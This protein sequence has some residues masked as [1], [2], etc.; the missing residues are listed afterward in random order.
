M[1]RQI[2][3]DGKGEGAGIT[4]T[5]AATS[6]LWRDSVINI[7]DSRPVDFRLRF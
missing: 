7:I 2:W 5:S 4:I 3:L 1:G 6:C